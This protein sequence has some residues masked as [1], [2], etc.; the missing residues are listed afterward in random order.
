M[1]FKPPLN[2][3]AA[4][5]FYSAFLPAFFY[6][7]LSPRQSMALYRPL[8]FH[9]SPLPENLDSEALLSTYGCLPEEVRLPSG[10][11]TL[12]G[13]YFPLPEAEHTVLIHHGN[14]GNMLDRAKLVRWLLSLNLSVFIYD[15]R[16]FGGSAGRTSVKTIVEDGL[17]AFDYLTGRG[18]PESSIILYGESLGVAVSANVASLRKPAALFLQS[19]FSSL[20]QVALETFPLLGLYPQKLYPKPTLNSASLLAKGHPP[21][22]IAHGK[23]DPSVSVSHAYKLYDA[24]SGDKEL[25]IVEEG[26]HNDLVANYPGLMTDA[27]NRLLARARSGKDMG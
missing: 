5:V 14:S 2:S 6:W 20:R 4:K 15:Y 27:L 21:L 3:M 1:K 11:Q 8:L 25:L 18:I 26:L 10:R 13:Y 17:C 7:L 9:P 23:L 22:L 12:H 19:G 24:A 16:G